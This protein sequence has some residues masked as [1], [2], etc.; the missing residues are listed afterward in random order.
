MRR[1]WLVAPAG[2]LMLFLAAAAPGFST[3]RMAAPAD[4]PGG[5]KKPP[6]AAENVLI[7][8]K[9]PG[10][11]SEVKVPLMSSEGADLP[12]AVVNDEQITVENLRDAIASAHEEEHN[13][14]KKNEVK[15][16]PKIDVPQLLKRMINVELIVQEA[17]SMGLDELPDVKN[18]IDVFSRVTLRNLFRDEIWK[19]IKVDE[20]E[21]EKLYREN[22]K[23]VKT[24]SVFFEKKEDAKRAARAIKAGKSFDDIVAQAVASG[25]AKGTELGSYTKVKDLHPA[26]AARIQKMKVGSIS[27]VITINRNGKNYFMIF[28]FEEARSVESEE[29]KEQARQTILENKKV[30]AISK[31]NK[32]LYKKFIKPD[33]KLIESLDY[34]PKGPGLEKLLNDKRVVVEIAD[35]KPVTVAELTEAM[36]DKFYH[37]MKQYAGG[38]LSMIKTQTLEEVVQKKL[39][40]KEAVRLGIDKTKA[41][42]NMVR[43]YE[44]SVLFGTFMKKAVVPDLKVSKEEM[45]DYYKVHAGEYKSPEKVKLQ[46]LVFEKKEDAAS[47]LEKLRKGADF[48]WVKANAEG[49]VDKNTKNLMAFEEYAVPVTS[50]PEDVQKALSGVQAEDYRLY[51]GPGGHFYVLYAQEVVPPQQQAFEKV[52][53]LI[54]PKVFAVNLNKAVD[55]WLRKLKEGADIK[56]YLAGYDK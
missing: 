5:E 10:A 19:D 35:D 20:N 8:V 48:D 38:K 32:D 34:G 21:V 42:K 45:R 51:E 12:V 43:E 49:Q 33:R 6:A 27:P 29:A 40:I 44:R 11:A 18:E 24:S 13:G 47:V 26:V 46:D 30:E 56:V 7:M 3:D 14:E 16:A 31:L 36:Q 4:E 50:L 15:T 41:Y 52:M 9:G 23:E 55:D 53:S 17:K 54:R 2:A 37:G 22:I 39:F 25:K 28:R 1:V